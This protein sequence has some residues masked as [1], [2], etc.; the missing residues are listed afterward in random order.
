VGGV[1][2]ADDRKLFDDLQTKISERHLNIELRPNVPY[3]ELVDLYG[4][5]VVGLHTMR[6]EHFGICAVEY[7]AAGL[8][9]V[10]NN[11]GGPKED[12]VKEADFLAESAAEYAQKAKRALERGTEDRLRFRQQSERFSVANFQSSFLKAMPIN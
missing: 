1:R 9:P 12:I 5:A 7:M 6:N 4:R 10:A 11:S 2:N 3:P 8:I